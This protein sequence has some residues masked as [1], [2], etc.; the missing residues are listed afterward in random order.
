L[1]FLYVDPKGTI[2]LIIFSFNINSL[3]FLYVD[4]KLNDQFDHFFI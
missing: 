4:P 2:S 1:E 3:E